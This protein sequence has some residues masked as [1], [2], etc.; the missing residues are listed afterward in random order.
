MVYLKKWW[1]RTIHENGGCVLLCVRLKIIH[2]K[3][4]EKNE[5]KKSSKEFALNKTQR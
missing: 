1:M 4:R 5:N 3:S 2:I